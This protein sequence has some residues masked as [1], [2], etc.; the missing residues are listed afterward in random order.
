MN[1]ATAVVPEAPEAVPGHSKKALIG[2]VLG[3]LVACAIWFLPVALDPK[4][5]HALAISS[6]M[7]V[8]WALEPIDHGLTG[9][10]GCYLFWAL[11]IVKF[12]TAFSGFTDNT[13]WFL[14]G[15]MIMGE[16]AARSGLASRIGYIVMGIIG[17]SYARLL[18]SVIVLV[19]ILN[20]LVPSG[21]AQLAIIAPMILGVMAA[22]GV[23]KGSNIGRGLFIILTY[24]CGLFNKM[25]LAGGA[26]ILTRGL[27]EKLTGKPISW[28]LYFIAYLPA[29]LITILAC[30]L[31]ILWLYPPEKKELPGGRKYLKDSLVAMGPWSAAEK[32]T[33]AWLLLAIGLWA[34]DWVHGLSPALV[35]MGIGLAVSLPLVGVLRTREIRSLNFLLI[36]FLGGALSMGEVLVKTK[37]LD[38]ITGGMM[39]WMTPLLNH[40]F[41][42][43]GVLYWTGFGY[44]FL[45]AS[46]LSM[47]STSLP[48][49]IK[50]AQSHH[51]NP[52]A[53][54]MLWNFASGGKLFVY[55]SSVLVLGYSYGQFDGKDML[56]VGAVLTLVEGLIVMFLVPIYWPLI[57]LQWAN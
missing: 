39:S 22:F 49:I 19:L 51:F 13:P 33:L 56:K 47:L 8:Y 40:P 15:A 3:P 50:F 1:S 20:F 16:A 41:M 55:Q 25:V 36:I 12:D 24:T 46:E 38:V 48:V 11:G 9:L 53:L 7:V 17:T 43:A 18:L 42:A 4:V 14:F 32:K 52:V 31:T 54:A 10:L 28:T 23:G 35:A 29:V 5:K 57:G 44:H 6:L 27:V 2:M 45:L 30:W 34:T 37:A 26:S 21:M